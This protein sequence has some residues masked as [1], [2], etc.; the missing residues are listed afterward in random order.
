MFGCQVIDQHVLQM[1]DD[2]C[3]LLTSS[4]TFLTRLMS[5][6]RIPLSTHSGQCPVWESSASVYV[7]AGWAASYRPRSQR[8]MGQS[9]YTSCAGQADP[10]LQAVGGRVRLFQ[11]RVDRQ[12]MAAPVFSMRRDDGVGR[13]SSVRCV[14]VCLSVSVISFAGGPSVYGGPRPFN[15]A[16][17]SC[18]AVLAQLGVQPF[19]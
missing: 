15:E 9:S 8:D 14:T 5:Q 13:L 2:R 4:R 19:G 3:G 11:L 12:F 1:S 16:R 10:R 7:T 6:V 18:Q 17:L